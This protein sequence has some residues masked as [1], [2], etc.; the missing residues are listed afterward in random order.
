MHN[1]TLLQLW[2]GHE[3][4]IYA[5]AFSPD[6]QTL[7]TASG[8][9]VVCLWDVSTPTQP[10]L[11]AMHS[12][13]TDRVFAVAFSADGHRLV[14]SSAD[15]SVAVWDMQNCQL[16]RMMHGH[17]HLVWAVDISPDGTR[18]SSGG[19]DETL[20]L[21]DTQQGTCLA[22]LSGSGPYVGMNISRVT[23]ISQVQKATLIRLGAV[24]MS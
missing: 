2:R 16:I 24:D 6:G 17:T 5:V 14:S 9:G 23:G 15:R 3:G 11:S 4:I 7:A 13:H 1:N 21:W 20:R 18:V 10:I 22:V 8:D 19:Q 12:G